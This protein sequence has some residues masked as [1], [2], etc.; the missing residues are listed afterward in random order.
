MIFISLVSQ[1]TKFHWI[2]IITINW[3][4]KKLDKKLW[5]PQLNKHSEII[6]SKLFCFFLWIDLYLIQFSPISWASFENKMVY[7]N[8][9]FH[10]EKSRSINILL[11]QNFQE[12][13][14]WMAKNQL[15]RWWV[16]PI[17]HSESVFSKHFMPGIALS[18]NFE[19]IV[20]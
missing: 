4:F 8:K 12:C 20:L 9:N 19:P 13:M 1:K 2:G 15:H 14:H 7:Q 17:F 5:K 3:I 6:Q 16:T 11:K 18:Y 10:F